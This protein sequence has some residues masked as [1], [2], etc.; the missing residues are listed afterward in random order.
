VVTGAGGGR[1]RLIDGLRGLALGGV[2]VVNTLS[3]PHVLSSPIGVVEP[4]DSTLALAVHALVAGLFQAKSYPLLMFL[5]GYAWAMR[6]RRRAGQP[7]S[8]LAAQRRAQMWRQGALG[9]V[10]GLFIYF[11]DILSWLALLGLALVSA[12]KLRL[13]RL[14]ARVVIFGAVW[15]VLGAALWL[16]ALMFDPADPPVAH[17]LTD[18]RS[19]SEVFAL[20]RY[21][22]GLFVFSVPWQ[23]PQMLAFG[24]LGVYAARLRLLERA[25][26]GERVWAYGRRRVLPLALGLNLLL[27]LWVARRQLDVDGSFYPTDL[28]SQFTGPLLAAGVVCALAQAWHSGGARWLQTFAPLGRMT[29]SWYVAHTTCCMLLFAGPALALGPAFGSVGLFGFGL[30]FWVLALTLSPLW[31]RCFGAGPLERWVRGA[32]YSTARVAPP[33]G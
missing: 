26:F 10:H 24:M 31:Q 14:R 20:Q 25:R 4:P 8:A 7:F 13:R 5:V 17:W 11:G 21:G 22:Y 32:S 19:W 1:D 9:L 6:V 29:M 33:A 12:P 30:A 2:L 15:L 3:F 18:A 27:A 23:L 28:T 16:L